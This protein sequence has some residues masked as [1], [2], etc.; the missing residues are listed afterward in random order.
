MHAE[1]RE[2]STVILV[3]Y[4]SDRAVNLQLRTEFVS[5]LRLQLLKTG[6]ELLRVCVCCFA[7]VGIAS[8]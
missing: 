1:R 7:A 4:A 6:V 5:E 2:R 3:E 8:L